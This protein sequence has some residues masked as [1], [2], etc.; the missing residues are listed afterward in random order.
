[1]NYEGLTS[2][3]LTM[4][5]KLSGLKGSAQREVLNGPY[6]RPRECA[7]RLSPS[8]RPKMNELALRAES[9]VPSRR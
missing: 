2:W 3:A 1:M 8:R 9:I 6:D 5:S 7:V 4:E